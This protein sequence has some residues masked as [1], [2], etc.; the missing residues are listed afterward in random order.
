MLPPLRLPQN[1]N[2]KLFTQEAL[3]E[4]QKSAAKLRLISD[5]LISKKVPN[6]SGNEYPQEAY[7]LFQDSY[8][9]KLL[10]EA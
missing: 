3:I 4:L 2:T 10:S 5:H 8:I 1:F 6:V 7:D 9:Q